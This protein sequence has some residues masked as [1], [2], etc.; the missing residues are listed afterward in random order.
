MS[1]DPFTGEFES[2]REAKVVALP[3]NTDNG[4]DVYLKFFS[5]D[6]GEVH[7]SVVSISKSVSEQAGLALL[8]WIGE[9][10][11]TKPPVAASIPPTRFER[12]EVI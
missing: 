6:G 10:T 7:L 4:P 12:E 9:M 2:R 11:N 3:L 5:P 8:K 1:I